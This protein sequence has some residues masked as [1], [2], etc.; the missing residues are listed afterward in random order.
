[1]GWEAWFT[2]A[3]LALVFALLAFTKVAPDVIFLAALTLLI[4]ANILTP[5]EALA[6]AANTGV[7]TVAV[8]YVVACGLQETGVMASLAARLLGHS[9]SIPVAQIR[10]M[11]PVATMSAF[12]NN[13]PIVVMW[14][15]V[16]D[17]WAKKHR[18]SPSKLM[19]PL[20]YA[21]ILGGVCTLIGTSTNLVVNGLLVEQAH[22]QKPLKLF[23]ISW[24]GVPCAI[25]GIAYILFASRWLL[26][27]R[28]APDQELKD[29]KEFSQSLLIQ[30]SFLFS[31]LVSRFLLSFCHM[32][33][34][35][36]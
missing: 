11:L 18:V 28:R 30:P 33:I 19:M 14:L 15:P 25:A 27:D 20:S 13:T 1:M 7:L 35:S 9:T 24:V 34:S 3:V 10:M 16:L 6:G 26:K 29:A 12:I 2:V 17:D 21:A 36:I 31:V 4:T 23:E 5:D 8:L 32:V 22:L